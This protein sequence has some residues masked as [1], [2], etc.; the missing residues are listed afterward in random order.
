MS[1]LQVVQTLLAGLKKI[2]VANDVIYKIS[3]LYIDEYRNYSYNPSKNG[4]EAII[5]HLGAIHKGDFLFFDVGA[6]I[7]DWTNHALSSFKNSKGHLFELSSDTFETLRKNVVQTS[8]ITL[9]NLGLSNENTTIE[10]KNFG[11]DNGG[12]T[13]LLN[14]DYHTRDFT[15]TKADVTR[16]DKYCG[17]NNIDHIDFL[18]IDTEG[19][20]YAVLE[21]FE[22]QF[23]AQS[24]DIIQFEYGYTHADVKT[25]MRDFFNFFEKYGYVVGR[26]TQSGVQFKT[27]DYTD[28]DFKSGPNYIAC[29]P[30]FKSKLEKF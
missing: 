20:E 9:N 6:N 30:K 19:V 29:L 8:N 13:L 10:F 2:P 12:N 18:K 1:K 25:L 28:N 24:I 22:A 15:L 5:T 4:E 17:E 7:G 3:N 16:G 14:S 23:K 27:F 21:G 11:K 26:L